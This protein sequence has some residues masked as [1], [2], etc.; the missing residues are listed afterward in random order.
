MT[1]EKK[2]FVRWQDRTIKQLSFVNNLIIG[3]ATGVLAFQ[4]NLVFNFK[5]TLGESDKWLL[6]ISL[7]IVLFS[8]FFGFYTAYNR[9]RSFH[10]TSQIAR[11]RENKKREGIKEMR[12][13]VKKLDMGTWQLIQVQIVL[14]ALGVLLLLL[15][16]VNLLRG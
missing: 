6:L 7:L 1:N 14:F 4:T 15:V 5:A 16:S 10:L 13:L 9:L 2:S 12:D 3:L 11:K 8:L